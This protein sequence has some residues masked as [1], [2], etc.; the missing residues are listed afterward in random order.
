MKEHRRGFLTI[1]RFGKNESY[2][3]EAS[4]H[5]RNYSLFQGDSKFAYRFHTYYY[6]NN[7]AIISSAL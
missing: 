1:G 7:I 2:R 5:R 6:L 4:C 3:D